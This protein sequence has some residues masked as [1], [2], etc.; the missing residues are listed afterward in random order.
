MAESK[1]DFSPSQVHQVD[2]GED[3]G[4]MAPRSMSTV[5]WLVVVV[6]LLSSMFLFALD[7]TVVAVVQPSIVRSLGGVDHL[8]WVSVSYALG[9]IADTLLVWVWP[10]VERAVADGCLQL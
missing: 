5:S 7:N 8:P 4:V 9:G 1:S 3:G 10:W 2:G 6:S